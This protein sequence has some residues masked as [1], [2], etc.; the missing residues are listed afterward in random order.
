LQAPKQIA[1]TNL[2]IVSGIRLLSAVRTKE[3]LEMSH[4]D[5]IFSLPA[6][7]AKVLLKNAL[8]SGLPGFVDGISALSLEICRSPGT[9]LL[10][11]EVSDLQLTF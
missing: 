8:F 9:F 7:P 1:F 5:R 2:E 10:V 6:R 3:S 11:R 4:H